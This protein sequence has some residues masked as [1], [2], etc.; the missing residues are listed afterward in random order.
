MAKKIICD[1]DNTITIH[2]SAT[3]YEKKAPNLP[4]IEKLR[5][6]KDEGYE[7]IIHTARNMRTFKGDI[8]KI[9]KNTL[10]II[11]KWLE[12]HSVPFDEIIVGKPWCDEG[13]YIDDKAIRP[14]EFIALSEK[15]I[16]R[17]V[18]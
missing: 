8:N 2:D 3:E 6:F 4:L 12:E 9:Q 15:K 11:E 16:K 14:D 10:P 13:F 17:L 5:T 7:I 1:L 18:R